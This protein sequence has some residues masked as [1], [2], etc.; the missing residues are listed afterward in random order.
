MFPFVFLII[1]FI[2]CVFLW[3]LSF[4][5]WMKG[6]WKCSYKHTHKGCVCNSHLHCV[7]LSVSLQEAL[8]GVHD[9][10][11]QRDQTAEEQQEERNHDGHV[12]PAEQHHALQWHHSAN[13]RGPGGG[14]SVEAW[15]WRCWFSLS[16]TVNQENEARVLTFFFKYRMVITLDPR[17]RRNSWRRKPK[18]KV[19]A[20]KC[21]AVTFL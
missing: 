20:A 19:K 13:W 4:V 11:P 10:S 2:P 14:Q 15:C 3:Y 12:Q 9:G 1:D 8:R 7:A 21:S 16:C 18:E 5:D 17:K 6:S